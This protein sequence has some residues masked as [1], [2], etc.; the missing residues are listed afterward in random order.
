MIS[1]ANGIGS[2]GVMVRS[3]EQTSPC[4]RLLPLE[5]FRVALEA[6]ECGFVDHTEDS[7]A[8]H[9][10][11]IRP[12]HVVMRKIHYAVGGECTRWNRKK[13]SRAAQHRQSHQHPQ[14]AADISTSRSAFAR[15]AFHGVRFSCAANARWNALTATR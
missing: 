15:A 10:R 6:R 5:I 14:I 11:K 4:R 13:Q 9:R 1:L 8:L 2:V 12:H 7:L 3:P